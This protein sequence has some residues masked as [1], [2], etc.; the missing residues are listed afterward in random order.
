VKKIIY[1][2]YFTNLWIINF[3]STR[4]EKRFNDFK[5]RKEKNCCGN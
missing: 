3:A 1:Q 2:A 4:E 5:K